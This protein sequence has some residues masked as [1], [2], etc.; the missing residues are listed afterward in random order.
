MLTF[1]EKLAIIESFSELSRND[2]SLGRVNFQY[3][4][5]PIDKKN[6]VYHLHPNGNGFVYA[7]DVAGYDA[8]AKGLVNIRDLSEADLRALIEKAIYTLSQCEKPTP[9]IEAT[10]VIEDIWVNEDGHKLT[11][12][13]EDDG[14][15]VYAGINL[16]GVFNTYGEATNYL[17]VEGF[18]P[19]K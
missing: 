14:F 7:K 15:Y 3:D 11:L 6:I 19:Y 2:V 10:S 12:V 1:T 4:D 17:E 9:K 18:L 8:D 13:E 16:D 5:S